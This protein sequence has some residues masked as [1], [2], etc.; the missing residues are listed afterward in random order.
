[1]T[2]VLVERHAQTPLTD[3][4]IAAMAEAAGGCLDLHRVQLIR[5]LLSADG[6]ELL[7][8]FNAADLESVRLVIKTQGA[9]P[10]KVWSCTSRDAP[11]LTAG[12]LA[13]ANVFVSWNFEQPVALER[14]ESVDSDGNVCLLNQRRARRISG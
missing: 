8:H 6:R 3:W 12:D 10:G 5:T 7:C 13:R 9:L 2:E 14:L 1:M 4:D 11:G